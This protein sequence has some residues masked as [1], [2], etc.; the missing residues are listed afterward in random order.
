MRQRV[1]GWT[2]ASVITC[3]LAGVSDAATVKRLVVAVTEPDIEAIVKVVG[4]NEVDTFSLFRGCILRK[5]LA[6]E[7]AV[8]DRLLR[9]DVVV[10]SGFFKE[11]AAIYAS[12]EDVKETPEGFKRPTW[13]DVS[14]DA[15]RVN[16]PTSTCE[17]YVEA[18]FMYGDPFFWLNPKNGGVIAHNV[19]QGLAEARPAQRSLFLA[20][21]EKLREALDKDIQRW[22]KA[23][24][25]L[26]KVR[27]FSAQCG[28]QNFAQIGGPAFATRKGTPGQL[29]SPEVLADHVKELACKIVLVD[30]NTPAEYGRAFRER[31]QARVVEVPSSL[32]DLKGATRY[33]DLFENLVKNLVE[34]GGELT[35][36]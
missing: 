36:P 20:N 31:T 4:G 14:R 7:P 1:L 18:S 13:I 34:A 29:P 35:G 23:L 15:A 19:A 3:V 30:P 22:Q 26:H 17:G 12:V 9:S 24:A 10:W 16:V 5:D 27:A 32:G 33:Q 28:W 2:A 6:V 21:A 8:R 25:P 11:S